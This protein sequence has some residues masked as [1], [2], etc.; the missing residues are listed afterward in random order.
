MGWLSLSGWDS[1]YVDVDW[2][3]TKLWVEDQIVQ[4]ALLTCFSQR[5][6]RRVQLARIAVATQLKPALQFAVEGQQ[7][8][9]AGIKNESGP[10][11]MPKSVALS[12][13][14]RLLL[15]KGFYELDVSSLLLI[16]CLMGGQ[17]FNDGLMS[18]VHILTRYAG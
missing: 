3:W 15:G 12:E 18:G 14:H 17:Q 4:A 5:G 2:G 13:D 9:M 10:R 1:V 7:N 16:G 6:L 11:D 8:S